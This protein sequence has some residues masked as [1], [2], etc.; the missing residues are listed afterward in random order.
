MYDDFS[1]FLKNSTQKKVVYYKTKKTKKSMKFIILAY[2]V[3]FK[4]LVL[5]QKWQI[6]QRITGFELMY[7]D[8]SLFLKNST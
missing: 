7:D 2:P 8:F 5:C 3:T 4:P 1:L 6:V